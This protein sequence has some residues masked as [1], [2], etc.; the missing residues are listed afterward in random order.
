MKKFVLVT[1]FLSMF[2]L[3]NMMTV[4]AESY[5]NYQ[6]IV[7][8]SDDARLLKEYSESEIDQIVNKVRGK[9]FIGW[10]ID[11]VNYDEEVEFIS[12]T[13]LKIYNN[14]FS[15]IKHDIT[16]ETKEEIK[17]QLSA[18]GSIK[19]SGKGDVKKFKGSI[20][21]NIKAS[22]SYSDTKLSKETYEFNIVVDPLTY[23]KIVTRGKGI[24]NNGV[25]KYY[26]FWINTKSGGWETFTV[27]T[28]Y[29]E[30]IKER[31]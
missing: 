27:T 23:V 7:F 16:L 5:Q 19:I 12:E 25:G 29:Y 14:G 1:L 22:V 9:K 4:N 31:I 26:L 18:S 6:E 21:A 10:K 30:I 11:I 17:Y 3:L 13:K 2:L 20:D 24:I 15:T 8:D 28:E